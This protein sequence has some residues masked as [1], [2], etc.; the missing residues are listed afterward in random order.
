VLVA[1]GLIPMPDNVEYTKDFTVVDRDVDLGWLLR[2]AQ[3]D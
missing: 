2:S 1:R 3:V